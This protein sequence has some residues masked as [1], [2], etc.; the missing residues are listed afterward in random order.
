MATSLAELLH[1]GPVTGEEV[2]RVSD[3]VI[4]ERDRPG[5]RFLKFAILLLLASAIASFGLLSDSLEVV[6]GAMIVAPLMLPIMGLAF[7]V[8]LGDREGMV[9]TLL[10][11]L[12]GIAMAVIMGLLLTLP[13]A[14]L[15]NPRRFSRS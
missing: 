7:S 3:T 8:S 2:D 10:V 9:N 1:G 12:A 4:F 11:S 13:V 6:I 14:P 15:L 5:P